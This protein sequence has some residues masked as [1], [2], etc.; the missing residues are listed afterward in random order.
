L[1]SDAVDENERLRLFVATN[2]LLVEWFWVDCTEETAFAV[3]PSGV[4]S[5]R[6]A[7]VPVPEVLIADTCVIVPP[8]DMS[9][10]IL[11]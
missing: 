3:P 10:A 6:T 9:V 4:E 7:M 11:Y 1:L 8:K 5:M 2:T